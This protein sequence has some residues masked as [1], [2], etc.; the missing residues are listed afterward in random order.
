MSGK[1][2]AD[3]DS[4]D[5]PGLAAPAVA[6][7]KDLAPG[8]FDPRHAVAPRLYTHQQEMLR[9]S[10][11]GAHCVVTTATGSGKTEAFLLPLLASIVREAGEWPVA[12]RA[13]GRPCWDAGPVAVPAWN[14]DKRVKCW[15][16]EGEGARGPALRAMILYPMNALVED[17]LSRLREALDFSAAHAAYGR[18]NGHFKGNRITFARYNGET[19]VPGHPYKL[20]QDG[21]AENKD[22]IN[23]LRREL[24]QRRADYKQLLAVLVDAEG[25][26]QGAHTE[27]QKRQA[28]SELEQ[29]LDLMSFFPRADDQATEMLHRWEMQRR[30]PD[31]LITNFSMLSIMLMRNTDPACRGDQAD[32]DILERTATWLS[33]DPYRQDQSKAPTRIFHLV[34]DELHLY[35]GTAGTEVAYLIRV[36]L[37]RLGL[38]PDSPQLRILASSASLNVDDPG[39]ARRTYRFL[40]QFFG[41]NSDRRDPQITEQ[42]W[43]TL[44]DQERTDHLVEQAARERFKVIQGRPIGANDPQ[45]LDPALPADLVQLCVAAMDGR[46]GEDGEAHELDGERLAELRA[47]LMGVEGLAAKLRAACKNGNRAGEAAVATLSQFGTRL[48]GDANRGAVQSLLAA[49]TGVTQADDTP[50]GEKLPRFRL[51]WLVRNI[52]GLWSSLDRSTA[53]G[54]EGDPR[55]TVGEL[56]GDFGTSHDQSGNR[57]LETLYCECCGT[58][59]VAGYRSLLG[60]GQAGQPLW[61]VQQ[62]LLPVMPDLESLPA[63]FSDALTVRQSYFKLGVFWP[64]PMG[65][66]VPEPQGLVQWGQGELAALE[67]NDWKGYERG[68]PRLDARWQR[69]F[70]NPKT[71]QVKCLT[72]NHPNAQAPAGWVDGYV[73]RVDGVL[74]GGTAQAAAVVPDAPAMPHVCPSCGNDY[75]RRQGRLSPIRSFRTGMNKYVQLLAKHLFRSLDAGSKLGRKLVA[76]SDSREAAAVLANGVESANWDENLRVVLFRELM[77]PAVKLGGDALSLPQLRAVQRFLRL[78]EQL[79]QRGE[80]GIA[81]LEQLRD[82]SLAS[83]QASDV[84][85]AVLVATGKVRQTLKQPEEINPDDPDDGARQKDAAQEWIREA[86]Q[87][88][89]HVVGRVHE[90]TVDWHSPLVRRRADQGECPFGDTPHEQVAII[91]TVDGNGRTVEDAV[92]WTEYF[93]QGGQGGACAWAEQPRGRQEVGHRGLFQVRLRRHVLRAMFGRIIYD[94]ETHGIGH[95]CVDP[96]L[97]LNPPAGMD[98]G[99]FRECMNSILRILG[100][101][102]RTNPAIYESQTVDPFGPADVPLPGQ[103]GNF[104]REKTRLR[105]YLAAVC[106]RHAGVDYAQLRDRLHENVFAAVHSGWIVQLERLWIRVMNDADQ[107]YRCRFCSRVHW[108]RSAR[109]CTRCFNELGTQPDG[110]AADEM[111]R[112]H[113][114]AREAL[115]KDLVRLHCEELTG[116]TDD[117]AQ[118]QRHFRNLFQLGQG[119]EDLSR[120]RIG[121]EDDRLDPPRPVVQLVDTIDLLSVTTT[122]EVGVDIGSLEAVLQAN[123]PPERFNYQQRVGRAGRKGQRFAVALTFCRAN[124]HDRYHFEDPGT[125]IASV[126]PQP[127]LSMR[128]DQAQIAKRLAAKACLWQAFQDLRVRW[129]EYVELPDT[130]GEFGTVANVGD[131]RREGLRQW[132]QGGGHRRDIELWCSAVARGSAVGAQELVNYVTGDHEGGLYDRVARACSNDNEYVEPNLAHRLAEAGI[133][134][135]YGMPTRVRNLYYWLPR[136]GWNDEPRAIERELDVAITDFQPGATRTKDKRTYNP[137]GILGRV[138][139]NIRG[140]WEAIGPSLP[141]PRWVFLCPR[142]MHLD[143]EPY[144]DGEPAP[145]PITCPD[146]QS[147]QLQPVRVVAPAGFRT[148]GNAHPPPR[149]DDS[150]RSGRSFLAAK[151]SMTGDEQV[152]QV[153]NTRLELSRQGRV[154]RINDN[155]GFKN[156]GNGLFRLHPREDWSL[157]F[158]RGVNP[159]PPRIIGRHWIAVADPQD[160]GEVFALVAPKTTD[161]LSIRAAGGHAALELDP[162]RFGSAVRAAYYSAATILTRAAA[163]ELDIDPEEFDVASVHLGTLADGRDVGELRLADHLANGAGFVGWVRDHWEELLD[164]IVGRTARWAAKSLPCRCASGC[165][166][167]L[168]GFRNRYLHGLLDWRIGY[169]L[170]RVLFDQGYSCG[171]DGDRGG[172]P[173]L[174]DW[175][176]RARLGAEKLAALIGDGAH[177]VPDLSLPTIRH[178]RD[179]DYVVVGHPFWTERPERGTSLADAV[180]GLAGVVRMVDSFNLAVRPAWCRRHL[181]DFPQVVVVP[182]QAPPPRGGPAVPVPM[183]PAPVGSPLV[184]PSRPKGLP[185]YCQPAF[186]AVPHDVQPTPQELYLVQGMAGEWVV[187]RL[188]ELGADGDR[189]WQ[190]APGNHKDGVAPFRFG[191]SELPTRVR[192]RVVQDG[193]TNG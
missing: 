145:G 78:C 192:A 77:N 113:Y 128:P 91:S 158:R 42:E 117:Q 155:G 51:H 101:E 119:L 26:L 16:E 168:H 57:V 190:F 153:K 156:N 138:L 58:L 116:Q 68:L 60:D 140:Y 22:K 46:S 53:S 157:E 175:D 71:A 55:R 102:Y 96:A 73:F 69:A 135:M 7:F 12:D 66:G 164:G 89:E 21:W 83:E 172:V 193:V 176:A 98:A 154:L 3:L 174:L 107:A 90:Q 125:M 34:V 76:F 151:T 95:V 106:Q 10:L 36:L 50:H 189:C 8:L 61:Q 13:A 123:M 173:S 5:L 87:W 14:E 149:G 111:R 17:Q 62:E 104:G 43:A 9:E 181:S 15:G 41:L 70:L 152:S 127:F 100:E 93:H 139:W 74:A 129:H 84:R 170:V 52:D 40:G 86:L 24:G 27:D 31:I 45:Q 148:D 183:P 180:A 165:S 166:K 47:A 103:R 67:A 159:P 2:L 146:C 161:V 25:R 141:Y 6:A 110:A 177:V 72:V 162:T 122:M 79:R 134:P 23:Q 19:P 81:S 32:G 99:T 126:P 163:V 63:G 131:T 114:Y 182:P 188:I 48:L 18:Q 112:D 75:S 133:L 191:P 130:H 59:L 54:Y 38:T 30:P 184:L 132:L 136:T 160:P 64:R 118:R 80:L 20:T 179:R 88:P 142:C 4:Q 185:A 120:E 109:T 11:G 33:G 178:N 144:R 147:Q 28:R 37:Q 150:G 94:L 186:E 187:G 97:P 49:L 39:T 108:H 65:N 167:C 124:S 85:R 121:T 137:N 82:Q 1:E 171:L 169:D 105:K 143:E 35:R 56:F 29:V 44:G 92:H 115:S